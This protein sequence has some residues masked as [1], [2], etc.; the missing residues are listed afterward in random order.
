MIFAIGRIINVLYLVLKEL[1]DSPILYLSRYIIENK[2]EC[3]RLLQAVRETDE[4]EDWIVHV[5]NGIAQTAENALQLIKRIHEA[6]D[7]LTGEI[8]A[9]LPKIYSK[10][11]IELLFFEF[12]TKIRVFIEVQ[13]AEHISSGI[14][15]TLKKTTITTACILVL[16]TG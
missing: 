13:L 12:Y 3:Y 5:L 16:K 2:S 1:I 15:G 4:W 11:L 8:R 9:A 14:L 10:E 6:I 7:Q